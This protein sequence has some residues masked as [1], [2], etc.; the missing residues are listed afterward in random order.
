[1]PNL[2]LPEIQVRLIYPRRTISGLK[3]ALI[4]E[5]GREVYH[6]DD[7]DIASSFSKRRCY[8]NRKPRLK[9]LL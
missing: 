1:V 4:C 2:W 8:T 7:K 5:L 6:L 9:A 3:E